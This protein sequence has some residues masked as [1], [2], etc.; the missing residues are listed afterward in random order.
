[1]IDYIF[2]YPKYT[3]MSCVITSCFVKILY[4]TY[5]SFYWDKELDSTR[6]N[7]FIKE[8]VNPKD[9]QPTDQPCNTKHS[10][11]DFGRTVPLD[12]FFKGACPKIPMIGYSSGLDRRE[13]KV[14]KISPMASLENCQENRVIG[15]LPII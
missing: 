14:P 2:L 4:D 11:K 5:G 10:L 9:I 1:M 15:I 7:S 13:L 6:P 12:I 8:T 3:F